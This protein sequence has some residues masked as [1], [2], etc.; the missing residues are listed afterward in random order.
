MNMSDSIDKLAPALIAA[1]SEMGGV[2]KSGTNTFDRYSY[3]TLE[4]YVKAIRKPLAKHGLSIVTSVMFPERLEPRK[5]AKGNL[6]HAVNV[7][8]TI[9]LVHES[10]QWIETQSMGEGQDRADKALY[11]AITGARKYG[12]ASLFNLATTDDP[13]SD[14]LVGRDREPAPPQRPVAPA[15]PETT[16]NTPSVTDLLRDEICRRADI[17]PTNRKGWG[18]IATAIMAINGIVV[19]KGTKA[20]D[21]Q[22]QIALD[23]VRAASDDEFQSAVARVVGEPAKD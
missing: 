5:T 23:W 21:E 19:P 10:G 4:D 20:S 11:K 14:E 22:R 6:E 18:Q 9:R 2:G 3:A 7:G 16:D 13:E 15:P 17:K 12:L 1:Q 8:I